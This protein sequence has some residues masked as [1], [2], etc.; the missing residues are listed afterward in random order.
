M[1]RNKEATRHF[2]N[3]FTGEVSF[4]LFNPSIFIDQLYSECEQFYFSSYH[5]SSKRS[6]PLI[7]SLYCGALGISYLALIMSQR[8]S[9]SEEN[10]KFYLERASSIALSHLSNT[11]ISKERRVSLLESKTVGSL[12]IASVCNHLMNDKAKG[13]IFMK[14]LLEFQQ[15]PIFQSLR[16]CECEVLYGKTGYLQSI[17]FV[18]KYTRNRT[19]GSKEVQSILKSILEEGAK[20]ANGRMPLMWEWHGK[21]YLGAAHGVVGILYVLLCFHE[22][23]M[24][25]ENGSVFSNSIF[26]SI[27]ILTKPSCSLPS[28]NLAS[29]WGKVKDDLVH[30]CHGAPGF[31]LLLVQAFMISNNLEYLTIA[32]SIGENVVWPRGLLRKGVGLCHGISG[33]AYAFLA[34][35]R[36]LK[37]T[38]G[39]MLSSNDTKSEQSKK[40][41]V[42]MQRATA[43]ASFAWDR[44]EELRFVPDRPFSLFEGI[45]GLCTLMMEIELIQ[46][47][48]N[49]HGF[50]LFEF[51]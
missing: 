41:D 33:N 37:H 15:L 49:G 12:A 14:N 27:M 19:Y 44:L 18:R 39:T 6:S 43:F 10:Q 26:D 20:N 5:Q 13:K 35:Y 48:K 9:V 22:E 45:G 16:R 51:F 23:I 4:Q 25:L 2:T 3:P 24:T 34:L 1:N 38:E 40:S 21:K 28:G 32:E 29:S 11:D 42:W 46:H 30:W 31:I 7:G 47:N 17:L 8:P 50:P 36:A